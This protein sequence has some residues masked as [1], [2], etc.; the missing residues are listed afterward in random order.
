MCRHL[1]HLALE[2]RRNGRMRV[3]QQRC[4]RRERRGLRAE[5]VVE[6]LYPDPQ[7]QRE[8]CQIS[9]LQQHH[10]DKPKERRVR[11]QIY[12]QQLH[13]GLRKMAN[14]VKESHE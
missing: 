10:A 6:Y 4:Q 9:R 11:L 5:W 13:R 7:P 3:A 14:E 12:P 2:L 8:R 1:R